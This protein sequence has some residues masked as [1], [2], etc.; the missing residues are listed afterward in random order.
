MA[1]ASTR[2]LFV[3][4]CALALTEVMF[5]SV[6]APLLPYYSR[7][8]HLSKGAAGLLSSSYALGTLAFALPVGWLVG[9]VGAKPATICGAVLLA[10]A[11]LAFG[12]AHSLVAL[13]AARFVQGIAGAGIW[14]ASLAWLVGGGTEQRSGEIVGGVLGVAVIGALLGPVIGAVGELTD[15]RLVF[16]AVAVVI[17]ALAGWALATPGPADVRGRATG[18]LWR[19]VLH[20]GRLRSGI[21][22]TALPAALFG[23]LS[24]LA[25]LRIGALGGGTVAVGAVFVLSAI[26]EAAASPLVGRSSDRRGALPVARFWLAGSAVIALALPLPD[27]VWLVGAVTVLA[28]VAFALPWVPASSLLRAGA[29]DHA[30][31]PGLAYSLWNLAWA[32][33]LAVGSAIGAPLAQATTDA[34]PY[35]ALAALC[36]ATVV[37]TRAREETRVRD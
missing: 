6:L 31:H 15:P 33:G 26:V 36:I 13:D 14:A 8:L 37:A 5:F 22:F 12:F 20:D 35:A 19:I 29:D 1:R 17:L 34:V 27:A 32:G 28:G 16:A 23:L 4:V 9:R 25:P 2:S 21:W 11:S 3:L 18:S 30:L 10:G 24:V 7:H